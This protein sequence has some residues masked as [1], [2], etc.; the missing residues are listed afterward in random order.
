MTNQQFLFCMKAIQLTNWVSDS[1]WLPAQ[2][3]LEGQHLNTH[4]A[5][6]TQC[7][8]LHPCSEAAFSSTSV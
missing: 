7:T 8:P 3:Y 6:Y 1:D 4:A 5:Q 2:S